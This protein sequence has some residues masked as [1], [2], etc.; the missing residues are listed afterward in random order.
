VHIV[1]RGAFDRLIAKSNDTVFG[2][3]TYTGNIKCWLLCMTANF[4]CRRP[5]RV[6]RDLA[7]HR[8]RG[9]QS[10]TSSAVA[11]N[12]CGIFRPNAKTDRHRLHVSS[13]SMTTDQ[14]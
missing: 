4:A 3:D 11:S 10:I 1:D 6:D 5:V 12:G 2:D 9:A 14:S 8:R 7:D 13:E